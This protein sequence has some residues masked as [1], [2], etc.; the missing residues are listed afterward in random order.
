MIVY[1]ENLV[2]IL[3]EAGMA[4]DKTVARNFIKV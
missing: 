4:L 1:S 3:I 2:D